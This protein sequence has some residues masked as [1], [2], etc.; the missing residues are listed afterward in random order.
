MY[1]ELLSL[2]QSRSFGVNIQMKPLWQYF[3]MVLFIQ[4]DVL[5]FESFV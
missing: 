4:R 2:S 1:Y 3:H 5:T